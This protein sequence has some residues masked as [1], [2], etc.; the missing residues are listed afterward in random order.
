MRPDAPSPSATPDV[1]TPSSP[2]APAAPASRPRLNLAKRTVSEAPSNPDAAGASASSDAKASPFGAARP[3][4]TSAREKAIEEKRQLAVR[5]KKEADDKARDEKRARDTAA[6]AEKSAASADT[7]DASSSK[8]SPESNSAAA[9]P[10]E[11]GK[12]ASDR[13]G[14]S[15]AA[16]E[17][18]PAPGRQYEILRRMADGEDAEEPIDDSPDA[19]ANG[20]IIGDKETK[21]QETVREVPAKTEGGGEWRQKSSDAAAG[22]ETTADQ[23]EDDGFTVVPARQKNARRGGARAL[24]S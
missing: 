9:T 13:K 14:S 12:P 24:A 18:S 2:A 15:A 8:D 3:I 10:R 11:N 4:D 1:S 16:E 23:L 17:S 5:Q 21:P 22:G 19:P 20:D 7:K 6:K